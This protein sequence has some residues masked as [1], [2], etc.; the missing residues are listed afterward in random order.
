MIGTPQAA[1]PPQGP[2]QRSVQFDFAPGTPQAVIDATRS[3]AVADR[4][5]GGAPQ[6]QQLQAPPKAE[7]QG[8]EETFSQPIPVTNPQ[9]QKVELVQFGN[10][11]GRRVV[12]DFAPG[13]TARENRPATEA[14]RTASGYH[15]RMV[16]SERELEAVTAAGYK[17]GNLWDSKTAGQGP[18]NYVAS[19]MGQQYRQQQEDWVRAKLRKESGAVI[20]D[21]EMEREI[22]TYFP[23][24]GDRPQV[25]ANK[26]KSRD[27][28]IRAMRVSAGRAVQ[29]EGQYQLGQVI[30]QGGKRYKVVGLSDPN[31][32]DVEEV[33]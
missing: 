21:D 20:G 30:E 23:Q 26:K 22:K 14:E 15:D 16:Q 31:D 29:D 2:Q 3:Y 4:G 32:P 27:I 12:P 5:G 8:S 9:T 28:A 13:P 1:M 11:G 25:I 24:P 7:P 6:G 17:E 33:R 10:R 18:L 19:D